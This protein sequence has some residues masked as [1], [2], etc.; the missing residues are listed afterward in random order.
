MNTGSGS[1][2]SK[3]LDFHFEC[4]F[5]L[6]LDLLCIAGYD[7]YFKKVNPAV[8]SV[9]EYNYDELY[10]RPINSFIHP[11]DR[12][13]TSQQRKE[14]LNEKYLSNFENRYIKKNGEYVWLSWTSIPS[15]PNQVIY[16]I[17]KNISHIK[18]TELNRNLQLA[19]LSNTNHQ[20]KQLSYTT[21]HDLRSP[22]NNMLS[23]FQLLD[24]SKITDTE[25]LKTLEILQYNAEYLNKVLNKSVDGLLESDFIHPQSELLNIKQVLQHELDAIKSLIHISGTKILCDFSA[26]EEV[27]FDRSYLESIFLNLISN[28]IKYARPGIPA[29]ISIHTQYADSMQQLV[30]SDNGLGM[31][32]EKYKHRLFGLNQKFHEHINDSKGVGLYLVNNYINAMGGQIEVKSTPNKGTSFCISFKAAPDK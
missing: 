2:I 4:F 19:K 26:F 29:E 16:A 22:V 3:D 9:L 13:I 5:E 1:P 12:E 25:T 14:L 27:Y 30:F 23:L 11:D 20:L 10:S 15:P 18:K 32:L 31:D 21:S 7:G 28:S 24:L 6:S 17:A 8:C